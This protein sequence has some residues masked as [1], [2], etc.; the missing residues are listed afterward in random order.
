MILPKKREMHHS[1]HLGC[2]QPTGMGMAQPPKIRAMHGLQWDRWPTIAWLQVQGLQWWDFHRFSTSK[3]M[4]TMEKL[5]N[6]GWFAWLTPQFSMKQ[7]R[8]PHEF[9]ENQQQ[10]PTCR[11][12]KSPGWRTRWPWN[13]RPFWILRLFRVQQPE[14]VSKKAWEFPDEFLVPRKVKNG[15]VWGFQS[16]RQLSDW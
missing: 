3:D 5:W 12:A 6:G 13:L 10:L 4:K 16:Y 14:L 8:I 9:H 7:S 2:P 1:E 11:L 15:K